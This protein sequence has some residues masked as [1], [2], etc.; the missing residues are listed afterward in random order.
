MLLIDEA[1]A[2]GVFGAAGRGL[3]AE[4]EGCPEIL[5]LHTGGKA[6]GVSGALVAGAALLCDFLLN[7]ARPFIFATAP[8]PLIAAALSES[9][10]ILK[11]E[12]ERAGARSRR[13]TAR[14]RIRRAGDSAADSCARHGPAAHLDHTQCR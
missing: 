5:V 13:E 2:T 14:G 9:L 1:H 12:P 7:R 4:Y 11:D 6:L 3:A 8:S 10:R